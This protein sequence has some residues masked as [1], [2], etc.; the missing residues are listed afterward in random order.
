MF[1]EPSIVLS[2]YAEAS[3]SMIKSLIYEDTA[4]LE[5]PPFIQGG[6]GLNFQKFRKK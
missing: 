2:R 6:G 4:Y 3:V 1:G 5:P